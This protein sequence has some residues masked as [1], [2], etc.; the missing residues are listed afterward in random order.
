MNNR[1]FLPYIIVGVIALFIVMGISSSIFY[2]INNSEAAIIFYK[3]G[4][5]LN[6]DE[7]ITQGFHMKAP[8][9]ALYV[10]TIN[11]TTR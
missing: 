10:Y 9:N 2:T 8:W 5:G 3:F 1:R 4:N 7:V 11:E 6:K